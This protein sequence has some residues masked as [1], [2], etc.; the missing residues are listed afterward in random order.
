VEI[1]TKLLAGQEKTFTAHFAQGR[2]KAHNLLSLF[3]LLEG[4]LAK[5]EIGS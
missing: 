2:E 4:G 1:F 3:I 5:F